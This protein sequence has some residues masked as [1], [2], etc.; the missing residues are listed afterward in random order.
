MA[1]SKKDATKAG[2]LLRDPKTPKPIRSV[3]ASDLAQANSKKGG[4]K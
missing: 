2:R 4:K 3:A 1:T